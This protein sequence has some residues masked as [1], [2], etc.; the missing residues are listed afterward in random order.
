MLGHIS[1]QWQSDDELM[2]LNRKFLNNYY[3]TDII[4]FNRNRGSR[5]QGDLAI[6]V[7]RVIDHATTQN[8]PLREEILRVVVHG[9]L[10]LCGYDDHTEEEKM[11]MRTL[12]TGYIQMA[13][14]FGL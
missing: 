12:E 1:I 5:V 9:V 10:H 11:Q 2:A 4:T 6:S 7:D 8:I 14:K 3:Y 13:S